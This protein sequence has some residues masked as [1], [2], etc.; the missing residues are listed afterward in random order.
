MEIV[1]VTE[2]S[3]DLAESPREHDIDI[4]GDARVMNAYLPEP[5]RNRD[6]GHLDTMRR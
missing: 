5:L 3:M 2:G 1:R 4:E 6:G